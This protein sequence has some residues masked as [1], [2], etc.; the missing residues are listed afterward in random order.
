MNLLI[1]D[2]I[3][4]LSKK[5]GLSELEIERIVD[6]QF[7]CLENNIRARGKQSVNMMYLG[8]FKPSKFFLNNYDKLH[9]YKTKE[10]YDKYAKGKV[11]SRG[12]DKLDIKETNSNEGEEIK[13]L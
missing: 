12:M 11:Y 6:T 1:D 10:E 5:Y 7:K 4:Q 13:N 2:I 3:K 9:K 8:K